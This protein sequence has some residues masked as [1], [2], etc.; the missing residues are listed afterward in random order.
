MSKGNFFNKSLTA[1]VLNYEIKKLKAKNEQ[2]L[3]SST[4][5]DD[6][7]NNRYREWM[8]PSLIAHINFQK[9][10]TSLKW[11]GHDIDSHI[12][13][14]LYCL[15]YGSAYSSRNAPKQSKGCQNYILLKYNM[16]KLAS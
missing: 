4:H 16:Y 8:L 11:I 13:S 9:E 3:L 7:L 15:L 10:V 5:H 2:Q 12:Y 6:H 1:T 14:L